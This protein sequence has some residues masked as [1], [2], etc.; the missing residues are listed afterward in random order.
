MLN[1]PRLKGVTGVSGVWCLEWW[2]TWESWQIL[3]GIR[4]T[5]TYTGSKSLKELSKRTTFVLVNNQVNKIYE[6]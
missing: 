6:K 4:S 2:V 1:A 5:L 3:G